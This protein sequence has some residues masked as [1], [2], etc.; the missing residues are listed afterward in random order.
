[1]YESCRHQGTRGGDG[2][3][4]TTRWDPTY[5]DTCKAGCTPRGFHWN[6]EVAHHPRHRRWG[7]A[8]D[9]GFSFE[10]PGRFF[11]LCLPIMAV[12]IERPFISFPV[13]LGDLRLNSFTTGT[14][15]SS[16]TIT[17]VHHHGCLDGPCHFRPQGVHPPIKTSLA[18]SGKGV[19]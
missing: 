3:P 5:H 7:L 6:Y 18:S 4:D 1:M 17:K 9:L 8:S 10:V 19:P 16:R 13:A 15:R 12:T 2:R 14:E 11:N